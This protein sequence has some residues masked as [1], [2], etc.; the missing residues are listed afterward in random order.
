MSNTAGV[1]LEVGTDYPSRTH[2]FTPGFFGG[3]RVAHLFSFFMLSYYVSL[4]SEFSV[5]MSV[6]ISSWKRFSVRLYLQLFAA[7]CGVLHMLCCGF[8]GWFF[9]SCYV[10]CFCGF[11]GLSIFYCP[12]DIL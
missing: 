6:T 12:F 5:V 3:V 8:W 9:F 11:S 4:L 10:P 1:L 7:H 2:E